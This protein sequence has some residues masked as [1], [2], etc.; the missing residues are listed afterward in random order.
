VP[1]VMKADIAYAGCCPNPLPWL[2]NADEMPATAFGRENV[3][4]TFL[5][6]QLGQ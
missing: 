2:L 3:R 4:A 6:G 5:A 1:K